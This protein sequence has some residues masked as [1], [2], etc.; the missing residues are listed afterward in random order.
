MATAAQFSSDNTTSA[1]TLQPQK[2]TD[3]VPKIKAKDVA[4]YGVATIDKNASVYQAIALMVKKNVTGLP[5]VDESGLLGI[6]TEK[7]A[8]KLLYD[9]EFIAGCVGDYMTTNIVTFDEE[10]DI[11]EICRCLIDNNFRRVPILHEG[12]LAAILSRADLIKANKDK[13]RPPSKRDR[14]N[15]RPNSM[16][17]KDVMK[18]G[19]LTVKKTTYIYEAM[20]LLARK[21]VTGLPVVDDRMNLIGVISEKDM[22]KLLDNSNAKS[23][24]VQDYMTRN[25]IS[26]D[27][28]ASLFEICQ[29]LINNNFR[30]VP[31]L[32]CGKL[33]GII[34]R[35]DI[36][37]YIMK[38]HERFF[39]QKPKNE[40]FCYTEFV[41]PGK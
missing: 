14:A 28:D 36:M 16:V 40:S 32:D 3:E 7:D 13:F 11:A 31:I 41:R 12:K 5:V 37:A 38:N 9:T 15:A 24:I 6:I 19:L 29:C 2:K 18:Y 23:G 8:L 22:L 39:A 4:Q 17:A 33:I 1:A 30:R 21:N 27:W 25:V 34:T 35:S 10:D 26:F 20:G